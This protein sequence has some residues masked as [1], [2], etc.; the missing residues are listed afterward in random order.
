MKEEE[1]KIS[2]YSLATIERMTRNLFSLEKYFGTYCSNTGNIEIYLGQIKLFCQFNQVDETSLFIVILAHELAHLHNHLGKD[3]DGLI[4][5]KPN[6]N[7]SDVTIKEGLAQYYTSQ[8]VKNIDKNEVI[9]E[10]FDRLNEAQSEPYRNH[11][12]WNLSLERMSRLLIDTRRVSIDNN[13]IDCTT[14]LDN[15]QI[16][17]EDTYYWIDPILPI[18]LSRMIQ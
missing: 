18:K 2:E 6:F 17:K 1:E 11:L 14:F 8:Y 9:L 3:K 10:A 15:M 7:G 4:W 16:I 13:T 12:T 5:S